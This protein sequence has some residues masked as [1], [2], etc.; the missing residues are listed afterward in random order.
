MKCWLTWLPDVA[1]SPR[2]YWSL[3]RLGGWDLAEELSQQR[4]PTAIWSTTTYILSAGVVGCVHAME[5]SDC[6]ACT[7]TAVTFKAPHPPFLSITN[8]MQRYTI[9]FITVNALHV[10]GGFSAHHQEFK[11]CTH[12]IGHMWSLL[13]AATSVGVFQLI[14]ASGS[15]KQA[16]HI[17]DAVCTVLSSWWWA[18]KPP[19]TCRALT[20]I[21]NIV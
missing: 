20:V 3:K 9:F 14:H 16:W 1:T 2:L 13:A 15:S 4:P 17:P 10:L 6:L 18:E 7:L 12:S 5:L 11:N 19:K 8:K 21:K